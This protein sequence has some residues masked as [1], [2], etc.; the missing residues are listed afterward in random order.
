KQ[1]AAVERVNAYLKEYFDLNNVRHR[2]GKKA[3][4]HFELVSLIYNASRL[5]S[6]R[7]KVAR[8]RAL[9]AA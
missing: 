5:A 1:R 6:D 3:K 9:A 2:T 8:N 7:L 4:V